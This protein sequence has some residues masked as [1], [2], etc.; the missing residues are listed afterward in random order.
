MN[1]LTTIKPDHLKILRL[2]VERLRDKPIDWVI[3]GSLGLALQGLDVDV[4]D[5]DI[6]TDRYG[7]YEIEGCFSE[8]V[9]NPVCLSSSD[10]IRSHFGVLN[11]RGTQVEIMGDIQKRGTGSGWEEPAD[12][13]RHRQWVKMDD[14]TLPVLDPEFEYQAYL[15]LGRVEKAEM[16]RQWLQRRPYP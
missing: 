15:K 2:I 14:M 1:R 10:R 3:T 12:L 16:I 11:V 7:A 9:V 5:I 4:G 8:Y 13:E 6:Q